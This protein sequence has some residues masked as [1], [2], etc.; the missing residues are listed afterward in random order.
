MHSVSQHFHGG[1]VAPL[2]VFSESTRKINILGKKFGERPGKPGDSEELASFWEIALF[3]RDAKYNMR[4]IAD[5]RGWPPPLRS[6]PAACD[7]IVSR[8]RLALERCEHLV[9]PRPAV[10]KVS[11]RGAVRHA[12]SLGHFAPFAYS[13]GAARR[14]RRQWALRTNFGRAKKG[15]FHQALSRSPKFGFPAGGGVAGQ[16]Q[17]KPKWGSTA[18][19]GASSFSRMSRFCHTMWKTLCVL[20]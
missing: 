11:L 4:A 12:H 16:E 8:H 10:R 14:R 5:G 3:H 1:S 9:R 18:F 19:C 7:S 17:R 20:A 6:T 13:V 15:S 2:G